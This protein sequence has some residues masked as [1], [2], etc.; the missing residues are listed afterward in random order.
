MLWLY[1]LL[2]LPT[3]LVLAPA[4]W[5]R[6]RRRGGYGAKFGQRFGFHPRLPAK[7]RPRIWLQAVSVGEVLAIGPIL[8]GLRADGVTVYLTTTTSTGYRLALERYPKLTEGIGYF[9]L[10]AWPCSALAWRR[11]APD[12]A[13]L[14]EGERWPEHVWQAERRAVPVLGINARVSDRTFRRMRLGQRWLPGIPRLLLGGITRLLPGSAQD[15]A[16]FRALGFPPERMTT[17]GNL[18]LDVAIPRLSEAEKAGLRRELGLNSGMILLGSSTWAGEEAALIA[19]WRAVRVAGID[20][21]L[22]LVPRH[23]E[24]RLVIERL[25][26]AE[27]LRCHLR[28]RGPAAESVDVTVADT[29]GE[30]R[31]LAQLGDIIFVGKSLPPQTEGQTPVEAATLGKPIIF[32]P[33]MGNFAVIAREL[34]QRGAALQVRDADH[35]SAAIVELF[36][37]PA[38]R[39]ALAA[40]ATAWREENSGATD[41][42]LAIIRAELA[43]TTSRPPAAS[44]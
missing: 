44:V 2:F 11:I 3:L 43:A 18:K 7:T 33:G 39:A 37:D 19:A 23:A 8:Q 34:V 30:L 21:G 13:I 10:D 32:G 24:R 17:T 4:Y 14:M 12:L 15:E 27:G 41:R 36:L 16:R 25:L 35:L 1:R 20:C 9:P 26:V 31:R 29:T 40:A 42:T 38:R 28:S 6:M 5:R 22:L